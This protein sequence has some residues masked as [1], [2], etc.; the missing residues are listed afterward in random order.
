[1]VVGQDPSTDL[2]GAGFLA[3]LQLL[4]LVT[5]LKTQALARNIYRLSLHETQVLVE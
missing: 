3:L 2:R 1:M 4:H 5:D